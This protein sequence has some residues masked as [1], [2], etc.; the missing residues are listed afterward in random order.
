MIKANSPY[1][2]TLQ[3]H[4][5]IVYPIQEECEGIWLCRLHDEDTTIHIAATDLKIPD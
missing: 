2:Y 1:I 3:D 5:F 4:N